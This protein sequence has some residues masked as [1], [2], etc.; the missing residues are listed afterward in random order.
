MTPIEKAD[1]HFRN[2]F[3]NDCHLLKSTY[4]TAEFFALKSDIYLPKCWIDLSSNLTWVETQV[5]N[6]MKNVTWMLTKLFF[7]F[8][9]CFCLICPEHHASQASSF[10][11]VCLA[12][13]RRLQFGTGGRW[14]S[15]RRA[16][17]FKILSSSLL[18]SFMVLLCWMDWCVN[19]PPILRLCLHT[20]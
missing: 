17:W 13:L 10:T 2:S 15:P 19:L 14:F 18:S 20:F 16:N 3:Q 8:C 5:N 12:P 6:G 7:L 1:L 11:P 9:S 4:I